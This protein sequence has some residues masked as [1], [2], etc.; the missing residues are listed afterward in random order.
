M[1]CN[2]NAHSLKKKTKIYDE[3]IADLPLCSVC[4][5]FKS[6]LKVQMQVRRSEEPLRDHF[7]LKFG[8]KL[9]NFSCCLLIFSAFG[10]LHSRAP[11]DCLINQSVRRSA[12]EAHG[13]QPGTQKP[14]NIA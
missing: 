1:G 6:R 11:E 2:I 10:N 3:K 5:G 8:Q 13:Q 7:N 12:R 4:T 9:F 14:P